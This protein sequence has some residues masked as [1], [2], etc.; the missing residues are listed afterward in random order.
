MG[1]MKQNFM[2]DQEEDYWSLTP[3]QRNLRDKR[4]KQVEYMYN[5]K[6][7]ENANNSKKRK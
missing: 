6:S 4:A 5:Y 1:K 2:A 7:R 3:L